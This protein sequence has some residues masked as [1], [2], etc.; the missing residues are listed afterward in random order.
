[1]NI[2]IL[3]A[4]G[5]IGSAVAQELAAQGHAITGLGRNLGSVKRRFPL[6]HW[7]EGDLRAFREAADWRSLIDG[8]D[9]VVNCAGA[10]AGYATG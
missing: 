6:V 9:A 7:I 5:F 2:L 4:T 8:I 1:M 3:G 10:L